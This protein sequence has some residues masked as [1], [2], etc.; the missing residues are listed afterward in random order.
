MIAQ[1][2]ERRMAENEVVF[3]KYNERIKKGF[4]ELKRIAKEEGQEAL[5]RD[6]DTPLHFYCECSDENCRQ[7]II[8][9]P[10]RYNEIH[11]HRD[12]FVV[13]YGHDVQSVERV[14]DGE[15]DFCVVEKFHTPPKS[16]AKLHKTDLNNT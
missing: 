13:T 11:K 15:A 14:I 7:R 1:L 8:L 2:S 5:V 3:R 10:S 12:H 9:K 6:E 4:D 16:S